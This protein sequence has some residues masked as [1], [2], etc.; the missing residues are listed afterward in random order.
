MLIFFSVTEMLVN[1]LNICS[2]DELVTPE[3]ENQE[4][5]GSIST[6]S[7]LSSLFSISLHRPFLPLMV[8]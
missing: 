4:G 1:V 6:M 8:F 5:A 7:L 3:E 2:D